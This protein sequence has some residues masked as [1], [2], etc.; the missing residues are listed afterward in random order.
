M[1]GGTCNTVAVELYFSQR[2]LAAHSRQSM[3]SLGSSAVSTT[4]IIHIANVHRTF[5][6]TVFL[7]FIRNQTWIKTI[8][9]H[10]NLGKCVMALTRL[11]VWARNKYEA[12]SRPSPLTLRRWAEKGQLPF[13]VERH[14]VLWFI[15]PDRPLIND[16]QVQLL[17]DRV[18]SNG[19]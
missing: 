8:T 7:N 17:I 19:A 5:A 16:P 3:P 1:C 13:H 18:M 10:H 6:P 11:N 12:D 14:G 15:D 4:A 9:N 2:F